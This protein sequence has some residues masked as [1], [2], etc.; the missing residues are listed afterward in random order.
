MSFWIVLSVGMSPG[1]CIMIQELNAWVSSGNIHHLPDC[2]R[3]MPLPT[4]G[5]GMVTLF[6]DCRGPWLIDWLPKGI[7]VNANC[8]AETLERLRSTI[9]TTRP[10]M[11]SCG[12]ILLRDNAKPH[13]WEAATLLVGCSYTF[14]L[15]STL[16][17][18]WLS[19]VWTNEK[20]TKRF[21]MDTNV[22]EAITSWL[23]DSYRTSKTWYRRTCGTVGCLSQHM[24]NNLVT[25]LMLHEV[26]LV[27]RQP[28]K[29]TFII[30]MHSC[31]KGFK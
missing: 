3:I 17:P 4:A 15:Q 10:S 14:L 28:L 20:D 24:P 30:W 7:I 11:L 27:I 26:C 19:C 12:V 8:Y 16:A 22:Q 18:P 9:Q 1:V 2:K 29:K 6:F 13:S 21:A 31:L 23:T 25:I 5:K